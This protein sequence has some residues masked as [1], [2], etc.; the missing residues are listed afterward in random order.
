MSPHPYVSEEEADGLQVAE[1]Q[2]KSV[3]NALICS[4][5]PNSVTTDDMVNATRL[6]LDG[7][8]LSCS[9]KCFT[10]K[11]STACTEGHQGIVKTK[12]LICSMMWFLGIHAA[13]QEAEERCLPSQAAADTKL[14][15]TLAPTE[16]PTAPW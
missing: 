13:V 14:Q 12:Q 11:D 15:E 8:T 9:A 6:F 5:L 2:S 1:L 16:L 3:M 7:T 4:N 10:T